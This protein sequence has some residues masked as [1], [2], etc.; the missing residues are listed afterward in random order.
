L[1][2]RFGRTFGFFASRQSL[3]TAGFNDAAAMEVCK[4]TEHDLEEAKGCQLEIIDGYHRYGALMI[5]RHNPQL[6]LKRDIGIDWRQMAAI[7]PT[8][9]TVDRCVIV[10]FT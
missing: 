2:L 5:I 4:V 7:Y 9:I 10:A 1:Y 6:L 3:A 8:W